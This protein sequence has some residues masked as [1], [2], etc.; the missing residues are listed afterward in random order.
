MDI[1]KI[2]EVIRSIPLIEVEEGN[3]AAEVF[4]DG[5]KQGLTKAL[6]EL[7]AASREDDK[8]TATFIF[9]HDEC[10]ILGDK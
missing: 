1:A 4:A 8:S 7:E 3:D 10:N 5:W 6:N 2:R 9:D